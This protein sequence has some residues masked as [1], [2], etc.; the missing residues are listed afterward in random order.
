MW[1]D[2]CGGVWP[3]VVWR[4][5]HCDVSAHGVMV[6]AVYSVLRLCRRGWGRGRLG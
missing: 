3:A 1:S 2:L 4:V 5:A 6:R